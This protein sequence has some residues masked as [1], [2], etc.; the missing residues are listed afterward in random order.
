MTEVFFCLAI[1]EKLPPWCLVSWF[2]SRKLVFQWSDFLQM[3]K[4]THYYTWQI[5]FLLWSVCLEERVKRRSSQEQTLK[6][7]P[8]VLDSKLTAIVRC[9]EVLQNLPISVSAL[10]ILFHRVEFRSLNDFIFFL[11]VSFFFIH[12][13]LR[14]STTPV[15][16]TTAYQGKRS[17]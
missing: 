1:G 5:V 11:Q 13:F 4:L 2:A 8:S 15:Q 7:L 10:L 17:H 16:S 6:H 14:F 12:F 9:P 3:Y